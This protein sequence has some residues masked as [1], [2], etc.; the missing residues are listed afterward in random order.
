MPFCA[1]HLTKEGFEFVKEKLS[2][3][4]ISADVA[5]PNRNKVY[6]VLHAM[7]DVLENNDF[8]HL[9]EGSKPRIGTKVLVGAQATSKAS[10]SKREQARAQS[11]S[12][13]LASGADRDTTPAKQKT[14]KSSPVAQGQPATASQ[15]PP[16][17]KQDKAK[18][19]SGVKELKQAQQA[20]ADSK[21]AQRPPKTSNGPMALE[22]LDDA[23]LKKKPSKEIRMVSSKLVNEVVGEDTEDGHEWEVDGHAVG[24]D[25]ESDLRFSFLGRRVL[26]R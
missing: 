5:Q 1:H 4:A 8:D 26:K 15:Q 18:L 25:L 24:D 2:G 13:S 9:E 17:K 11:S 22:P 16:Q 12:S 21:A 14:Q 10:T 7:D 20:A 23:P 6:E 19:N 3:F